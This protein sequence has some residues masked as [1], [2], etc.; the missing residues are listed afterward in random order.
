MHGLSVPVSGEVDLMEWISCLNKSSFQTN[1]HLWGNFGNKRNNH[2]QYPRYVNNKYDISQYHIYSAEWDKTK[3]IVRVDGVAV[4]SWY[5]K[6]YPAWPFNCT[7]EIIIDLAYGGW[8]AS[9]GEDMMD[10]PQTMQIDWIKY[11]Q[12]TN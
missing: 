8:G 7:Y 12:L 10:L 11:Y 6:D 9:C 5:S 3:L 2:T 4:A 1:F